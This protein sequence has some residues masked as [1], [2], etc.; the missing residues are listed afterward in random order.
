MQNT[1]TAVDTMVDDGPDANISKR[2]YAVA[3][4]AMTG[5][6]DDEAMYSRA[7]NV[8]P[9]ASGCACARGRVFDSYDEAKLWLEQMR[10]RRFGKSAAREESRKE[11][12]DRE[13]TEILAANH[14][15]INFTKTIK[16]I[17]HTSNPRQLLAERLERF[18]DISIQEKVKSGRTDYK[19]AG[20]TR[21]TLDLI[22]FGQS[23]GYDYAAACEARIAERWY[24]YR[25]KQPGQITSEWMKAA[26]IPSG[27]KLL[28]KN[29]IS[30]CHQK[31]V[32]QTTN[33]NEESVAECE[34]EEIQEETIKEKVE[35]EETVKEEIQH[36]RKAQL[37]WIKTNTER[38]EA[39]SAMQFRLVKGEGEIENIAEFR[40]LEH[41]EKMREILER[42]GT[43]GYAIQIIPWHEEQFTDYPQFG[44][45]DVSD[46]MH[47][48]LACVFDEET[49]QILAWE[50]RRGN[51][52][53]HVVEEIDLKRNN[54]LKAFCKEFDEN[55]LMH[56]GFKFPDMTLYEEIRDCI[57]HGMC[58]TNPVEFSSNYIK[59]YE[60]NAAFISA[61]RDFCLFCWGRWIYEKAYNPNAELNDTDMQSP[62][63]KIY[64]AVAKGWSIGIFTDKA[65][66]DKARKGFPCACGEKFYS[67]FAAEQWIERNTWKKGNNVK[68]SVY[69]KKKQ[70]FLSTEKKDM[71]VVYSSGDLDKVLEWMRNRFQK[72]EPSPQIY[73]TAKLQ[74]NLGDILAEAL[75]LELPQQEAEEADESENDDCMKENITK[76]SKKIK[77][78][79]ARAA[80]KKA[81]AISEQKVPAVYAEEIRDE[82]PVLPIVKEDTHTV[83]SP[84]FR[85]V[86]F[87]KH[88]FRG[89]P[90]EAQKRFCSTFSERLIK[91]EQIFRG[92][93]RAAG[94][95]FR[96]VS[97]L[98]RRVFKRRI[99]KNRLS[100]VFRDGI[101]TLLKFSNHDRQ[102]ADIR[103]IHGKAIGYV[104]YDM[105]DFLRQMETWP[106][107]DRSM[108][109]GDYMST[110]R[111][112]IFDKDQE[113]IIESGE[114][115]ENL[116]VIGNA[117]AGKSVVGLKWLNDQL[118]KPKHDCLYLTMSENLVYTLEFE[119]NKG[120]LAD[121]DASRA[122]IRTTFDF[123]RSSFKSKYPKIAENRLLNAAQ[124]FALFRRFWAEEVDWKQFRNYMDEQ[125]AMQSEEAVLLA[126]WREIHGILKGAVPKDVDYGS[127][128]KIPEVLSEKA[129]KE[130]LRQEKKDSVRNIRWVDTLYKTYE[131]YRDYLRRRQLLDDNDVARMLLQIKPGKSKT[132]AA[133]F[134]DECQDLTQMELLAIFHLLGGVKVK[135]MSS[136]RCQMVQP[137]Y[138]DEGW[139]RT[140]A[141]EYDRRLGK[142][143]ENAELKPRY[144]HYNYRSSRSIIDFQNYAV[145]YLRDNDIL[146]LKQMETE[147]IIAP[148][149]TPLGVRPIW[150]TPSDEN[151]RTLIEDLWKKLDASELQT[152]FAF[153]A[154][155][156]KKDFPLDDSDAVTDVVSCKGMEYPSVLLYNV[157][158]ETRFDS[159]MA[160]KYFYVGATRGNR[161]LLIYEKDAVPGT[162]T[163]DF[164][165]NAAEAGL[166]D[167]CDNLF[168]PAKEDGLTWLGYIYQCVS[169]N[170]DENRMETAENALNFGQY[171]LALS[172]FTQEGKDKN[173]IAYCRGKVMEKRG[174]FHQAVESYANLDADWN[175]RGRTRENSVD[176]IL[177]HPDIEG[178][179]FLGAYLLSRRGEKDLLTMAK[180]EWTYKYGSKA[181]FYEAFYEALELYPFAAE[182]FHRW[183]EKMLE[184]TE[185]E[186]NKIRQTAA[187][188]EE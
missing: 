185:N 41:A 88:V 13:N 152:I 3:E 59:H 86:Q 108:S 56:H 105:E 49:G 10:D 42:D 131:K 28:M 114:K 104:Y 65:E 121:K 188:W 82:A 172:I 38:L 35:K 137:T 91:M 72:E 113:A 97:P 158:T 124:S 166:I 83:G 135:R 178:A 32:R 47:F 76:E 145:R 181:G 85:G 64:Y 149:L 93:S 103:N 153:P 48:L 98:G 75:H 39:R 77:K 109:F 127:M 147:K 40:C 1:Q 99:G 157:L 20:F 6:F 162:G 130:R 119:F 138:F 95:D 183:T 11:R 29:L 174:D 60:I 67:K 4:G 144:L 21:E 116:S 125:S 44:V 171:E 160:W 126:A 148:P 33:E 62:E 110:P 111:H 7:L 118:K 17:K 143:M 26:S 78:A 5:I 58:K 37:T 90:P 14:E 23:R 24:D 27:Y 151:Q 79:K 63:A 52:R 50:L 53:S 9:D 161:C 115:A 129:Y 69:K 141:N 117:G 169:E 100:M 177:G 84:I 74:T 80:R 184:Q 34:H 19:W 164:L 175:D 18:L 163:Y 155:A 106:E 154:S 16:E 55:I 179:E 66:F 120:R 68:Y 159:G 2:Y 61:V 139:M 70:W 136:D 54:E 71:P 30:V 51:H 150:I 46:G 134:V 128:G 182:P 31:L 57:S 176:G 186:I 8:S 12:W 123:L 107:K 22:A 92:N 96:L 15:I 45:Y 101:L 187:E 132:Y 168:A 87:D 122:D 81:K 173:M 102:M 73:K 167:R 43:Y 133:V 156:A 112:F 146:T 94:N 180:R 140:T 165:S 25:F 89:M 170:A 142:K 36:V